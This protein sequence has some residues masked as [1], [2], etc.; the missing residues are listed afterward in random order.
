MD[1]YAR[2]GLVPGATAEEIRAAFRELALREH[3]DAGGSDEG[4]RTLLA[5]YRTALESCTKTRAGRPAS[6]RVRYERDVPS[7]TIDELP[8]VAFE[9][10]AVVAGSIG[11]IADEEP[12]YSIEFVIREGEGIWCRCDLVPDAGGSTVS[13]TVAPIGRAPGMGCEEV[14]DLLVAELNALDW[15]STPAR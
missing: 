5:A 11:D 14:R 6:R 2:L 7:F 15:G 4:M 8:V 13:V 3:P 10:L 9:G 1:P 12:P